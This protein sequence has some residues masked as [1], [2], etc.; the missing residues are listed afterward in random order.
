MKQKILSC[1]MIS[2]NHNLVNFFT[3]TAFARTTGRQHQETR[4]QFDRDVVS[5]TRALVQRQLHRPLDGVHDRQKLPRH[6]Q[7]EDHVQHTQ[8]CRILPHHVHLRLRITG[9]HELC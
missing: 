4:G 9:K 2:Q 5:R 7:Q 8:S 1:S 3:L 6:D